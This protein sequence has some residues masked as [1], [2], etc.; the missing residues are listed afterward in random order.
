[1]R[2][3][4]NG[5]PDSLIYLVDRKGRALPNEL[6]AAVLRQLADE[7]PEHYGPGAQQAYR[8]W[9]L[10]RAKLAEAKVIYVPPV[11]AQSW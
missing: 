6:V 10:Q 7:V 11:L 8:H 9:L 3:S 5:T 1:M 2:P 4:A